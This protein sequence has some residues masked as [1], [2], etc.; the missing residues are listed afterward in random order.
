MPER[1]AGGFANNSA[2]VEDVGGVPFYEYVLLACGGELRARKIETMQVNVGLECNQTCAHCHVDASPSRTECMSPE[3]MQEVIEA[4]VRTR[5]RLVEITG[6]APELHTKIRWF[7]SEL[8]KK[9]ISVRV[10]TNLTVLL[11]KKLQDLPEL[12]RDLDVELVAS[13]PWYREDEVRAQ[14]GKA[15]FV[16][17]IRVIKRLN[18]LGYGVDPQLPLNLVYNPG[19]AYLPPDQ[20]SLEEEYRTEL[21]DRFGVSFTN[22]WTMTN[23][24]IGRFHDSLES[25]GRVEEY[26]TLLRDSFNP[27]TVDKVMCRNQIT[28]NWD[29]TI[30]DCDFNLARNVPVVGHSRIENLDHAAVVGRAIKT[31]DH[32]FGCTA[33]AGSSCGGA[34][35][36]PAP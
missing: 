10:R 3:L 9:G 32:C 7:I 22:L 30:F 29:G 26:M 16:K 12:F 24:P 5:C 17:S 11:S 14:R 31:G 20:T 28:V 8:R 2:A 13:L 34:L 15:T 1:S 36:R 21:A 6:G 35:V 33:G 4:A 19:A 23:M 25:E 18:A 27:E